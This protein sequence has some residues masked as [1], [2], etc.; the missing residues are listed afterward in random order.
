MKNVEN[1]EMG[2]CLLVSARKVNGGKVQLAFAQKIK[3]S[4]ARPA[5]IVGL[6]NASDDRFTQTGK[7]RYAWISVEPSDASEKLGLDFSSL[8]EVGDTM[9]INKL[10]PSIDGQPLN[11]QITETTE[12]TE[13]E[14]A[15]LETAAKRAGTDG[16]FILTND[17]HYIFMHSTVVLGEPQHY[18]FEN[19]QR[20]SNAVGSVSEGAID[21]AIS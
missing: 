20:A 9:D 17:G 16:E 18:F 1:L 3:N 6:L 8:K 21:K 7:P 11:I 2:E 19:T 13:W 10:N 5:S 12:G 4:A 15:N 14:V